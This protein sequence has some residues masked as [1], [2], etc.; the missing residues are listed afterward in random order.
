LKDRV[1]PLTLVLAAGVALVLNS[2]GKLVPVGQAIFSAPPAGYSG[3][4]L[5]SAGEFALAFFLYLLIISFLDDKNTEYL[6]GLLV[7]GA[8]YWNQKT[9]ATPLIPTLFGAGLTAAPAT[10]GSSPGTGIGDA[11]GNILGDMTGTG[12]ATVNPGDPGV[13]PS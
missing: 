8:L 2:Q 1:I 11:L 5:S 12:P 9:S 10:P 7:L 3:P 13:T 6:T 4:T